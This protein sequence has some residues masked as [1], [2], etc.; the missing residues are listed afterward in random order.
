MATLDRDLPNKQSVRVGYLIQKN[1]SNSPQ[2]IDF[3]FLLGYNFQFD[4][5]E[6]EKNEDRFIGTPS[7]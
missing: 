5:K 2:E 4:W 7:F 3:V 1:L 6:E